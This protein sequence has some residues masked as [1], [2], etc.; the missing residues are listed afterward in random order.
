MADYILSIQSATGA[1]E[2]SPGTGIVNHD[3]TMEY[4]LMALG[5]AYDLTGKSKYLVGLENGIAWL[6][7]RQEMTDAAWKGSWWIAYDLNGNHKAVSPGDG[8]K[9]AR[10]V[11]TTAALFVYLLQLDK[12][13]N[14]T[15]TLPTTY[16]PNA[17]AALDFLQNKCM[18]SDGCTWSSW[19]ITNDD[20]YVQYRE[21]YT[22]DQADVWM[23]LHAGAL[24]YNAAKYGPMAET[25][26]NRVE[27]AF[28]DAS[29]GRY[30]LGMDE[31]GGL[32]W[33]VDGFGPLQCQGQCPW[34]W[35]PDA[36]NTA[37]IHW[38]ASKVQTDGSLLCYTADPRY[39]LTAAFLLLG[40]I[41]L[42]QEQTPTTLQWL[43]SPAIFDPSTG[44]VFDSQRV[45]SVYSNNTSLCALALWGWPA[46]AVINAPP[47]APTGLIA[48]PSNVQISLSWTGSAD[49]TSYNVYRGTTAGGEASTPIATGLSVTSYVN[50]GLTNG[51]PYFYRVAAVNAKGT[52]PMSDEVSATPAANIAPT[53]PSDLIAVPGNEQISLSWS[54]SLGADSYSVYRGTTAGGEDFITPI[55]SGITD[56]FCTDFGPTDTNLLNGTTY[57][58]V[59]A[60]F[61]N[62]SST[63]S[64]DRFR[65]G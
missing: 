10:G 33:T 18:D 49:A 57:Y 14:P 26:K 45:H 55:A 50:T 9:D 2:D 12:R 39:S 15:T 20:T 11:D 58:Y 48:T 30:A 60:A 65:F 3:S 4:A 51:T 27:S 47:A 62:A 59:I 13:V 29:Q 36:A 21:K 16:Q 24:L 32:D 44:G 42:G 56:L 5:A 53:K 61:N 19:Q 52:S 35:G 43:A 64:M 8:L 17:I 37:A 54:V 1:I 23:G 22:A 46:F 40:E 7:A 41:G 31:V 25:L 28:F 34:I 38:L 6:A 63:K